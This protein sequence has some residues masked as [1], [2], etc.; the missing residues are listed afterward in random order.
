M[1]KTRSEHQPPAKIAPTKDTPDKGAKNQGKLWL[2]ILCFVG[3]LAADLIT[4][5]LYYE[6]LLEKRIVVI[7]GFLQF[8]GTKNTGGVFG[9]A[10][11]K[12]LLLIPLSAIAFFILLKYYKES[13]RRRILPNIATGMI[14]AGAIGNFYDR[15]TLHYVRDF[16]Y[17]SLPNL[18]FWPWVYNVADALISIG[19]VFLAIDIIRTPQPVK[20]LQARLPKGGN[21]DARNSC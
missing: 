12:V 17:M 5:S 20:K 4:K 8:M 10:Q 16:I 21:R 1:K 19:V 13:D 11:G 18:E 15:V 9:M 14:A 3:G 6:P 7:P 2:A